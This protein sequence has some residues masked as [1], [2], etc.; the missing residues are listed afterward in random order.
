MNIGFIG[1]GR[2]GAAIASN[3]IKAG[4]QVTVWNRTTQK[5]QPLVAAGAKLAQTPAQAAQGDVVITMLADDPAVEAVV[6]GQDGILAAPAKPMH[7]SMSTISVDLAERLTAAYAQGGGHF[8]SAPVFGRPAAAEEAKL[9]ILAAGAPEAIGLCQPVFAAIGQRVFTLGDKPSAANLVKLCGNF[10]ILSAIEAMAEA[11]TLAAKGG[12]PKAALLEVLTGSLFN[13]PVYQNYGWILVEERFKP[14]AF[15]APLALKDMNLVA[16]AANKSRAPM[17][18]L[19]VVRDHLLGAI[20]QD[21]E[22]VDA[23]GMGRAVE[24]SAGL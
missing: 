16:A 5:A 14:A 22:D 23:A 6:F 15:A 10:M 24:R 20:A 21:G 2:M 13:S 7:I 4:H 18:F 17:P 8:I 19:G 12:V 3:L 11:M 1:L 9:F